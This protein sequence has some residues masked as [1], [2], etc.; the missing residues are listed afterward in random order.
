MK[1]QAWPLLWSGFVKVLVHFLLEFT[2]FSPRS[3]GVSIRS[4]VGL[5]SVFWTNAEMTMT[6]HTKGEEGTAQHEEGEEE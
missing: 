4:L 1:L 2:I 3:F 5:Q 6:D